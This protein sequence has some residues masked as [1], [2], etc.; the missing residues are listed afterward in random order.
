MCLFYYLIMFGVAFIWAV[1]NWITPRYDFGENAEPFDDSIMA[2]A[3]RLSG[4]STF[5]VLAL[6]FGLVGQDKMVYSVVYLAIVI[7][8]CG[9]IIFSNFK[10]DQTKEIRKFMQISILAFIINLII[11]CLIIHK[12]LS[13]LAQSIGIG[14]LIQGY[15]FYLFAFTFDEIRFKK[16]DEALKNSYYKRFL[17]ANFNTFNGIV[18]TFN[19]IV[20]RFSKRI[21]FIAIHEKPKIINEKNF[22]EAAFCLSYRLVILM[23]FVTALGF[24]FLPNIQ[25]FHP[26]FAVISSISSVIVIIDLLYYAAIRNRIGFYGIFKPI[27]GKL[28]TIII[29]CISTWLIAAIIVRDSTKNFK[30][31]DDRIVLKRATVTEAFDKWCEVF[32]TSSMDT[33]PVF[34]IA[35]QGGGSR[36]AYWMSKTLT[37]LD[38]V[39]TGLFKKHCFA[40]STVSGSSPGTVAM[41]AFWD[42]NRKQLEDK[43]Y[44]QNDKK[45]RY[46]SGNVFNKNYI[47]SGIAGNFFGDYLNKILFVP[48]KDRNLRLQEEEAWCVQRGLDAKD[49]ISGGEFDVFKN[50]SIEKNKDWFL[51]S[52]YIYNYYSTGGALKVNNLPYFIANTCNVQTGK[53][54]I[55][56]PFRVDNSTFIGAI[57]VL[58]IDTFNFDYRTIRRDT[59]INMTM[60]Q[61]SNITELFPYLSAAGS[62]HG[63]AFVDGGYFENYGLTTASEIKTCLENHL[64]K[65]TTHKKVIIPYII[66][67]INSRSSTLKDKMETG[68]IASASQA[69]APILTTFNVHFGGY[70]E[71]VREEAKRRGHYYEIV[72]DTEV[73]LTRILTD[74]N[75]KKMDATLLRQLKDLPDFI[76]GLR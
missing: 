30:I 55:V 72:L 60:G 68:K 10:E 21:L 36:A 31:P 71:K 16:Q 7:V 59:L 51:Y 22:K 70:A 41:L 9:L 3:N 47:T 50:I 61:A 49:Y 32:D 63:M 74:R 56:S 24:C 27:R 57:D 1:V 42:K 37:L 66:S 69:L 17:V 54:G 76:K 6:A 2:A 19:G 64:S 5:V 20:N 26:F 43:A 65:D 67:I 18:N 14:F 45:W 23:G 73:P 25:P 48:T 62:I 28:V 75:I 38:S 8:F 29:F 39:T 4:G 44:Y 15:F 58:G 13:C 53:R 12:D 34:I 33:I 35:G 11:I 52:P 40:I 46:Y